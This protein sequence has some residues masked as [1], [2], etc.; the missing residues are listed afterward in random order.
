[1]SRTSGDQVWKSDQCKS[2]LG[3][4]VCEQDCAMPWG[5]LKLNAFLAKSSLLAAGY[6]RRTS[7]RLIPDLNGDGKHMT[8]G[9]PIALDEEE[10]EEYMRSLSN[11]KQK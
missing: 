8:I 6:V 3:C 2:L 7:S 1:M 11:G 5:T 10:Y 4:R 9:R